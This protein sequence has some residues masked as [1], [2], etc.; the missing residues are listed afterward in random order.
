MHV[1]ELQRLV[2]ERSAA[3]DVVVRP[4]RRREH[5]R[6]TLRVVKRLLRFRRRV[7]RQKRASSRRLRVARGWSARRAVPSPERAPRRT[8]G[9]DAERGVDPGL[10]QQKRPR[11]AGR[12]RSGRRRR[13]RARGSRLVLVRLGR[14]L[15]REGV[16]LPPVLAH[17]V[18]GGFK[19]RQHVFHGDLQ[20]ELRRR[21]PE[22]LGARPS[23]AG[24]ARRERAAQDVHRF[25]VLAP[26]RTCGRTERRRDLRC[27][28][29]A[30]LARARAG[31]IRRRHRDTSPPHP[32]CV[33]SPSSAPTTNSRNTITVGKSAPCFGSRQICRQSRGEA[34]NDE[35]SLPTLS[36]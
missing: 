8:R 20:A 22:V 5:R 16:F 24:A 26:T 33:L 13:S 25:L 3:R 35:Q 9:G 32:S 1:L 18:L 27:R 19:H 31:C 7:V 14:L 29:R 2:R 34:N 21:D 36:P 15:P 10:V 17:D 6:A 30:R 4:P 28:L 12:F 23:I 11:R